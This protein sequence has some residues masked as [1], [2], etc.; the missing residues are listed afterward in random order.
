MYLRILEAFRPNV[1]SQDITLHKE[2]LGWR[3]L[4][5]KKVLVFLSDLNSM[6]KQLC[7]AEG[8]TY[9]VEE[10]CGETGHMAKDCPKKERGG[11]AG[12]GRGGGRSRRNGRGQGGGGKGKEKGK[13]AVNLGKHVFCLTVS[14]NSAKAY[15]KHSASKLVWDSGAT[16]SMLWDKRDF[17][18]LKPAN[19]GSVKIPGGD[20]LSVATVGTQMLQ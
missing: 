12:Y 8:R 15:Q 6:V 2:L 9:R 5:G 7:S 4:D 3:L 10:L 11:K 14:T 19:F 17:L 18:D 16:C 1:T 13:D 20:K